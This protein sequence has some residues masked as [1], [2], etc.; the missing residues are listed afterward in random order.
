MKLSTFTRVILSLGL[1]LAFTASVTFALDPACY[2]DWQPVR[3]PTSTTAYAKVTIDGAPAEAGDVVGAFVNGECRDVADVTVNDGNAYATLVISGASTETVAFKLWDASACAAFDIDLT[4]TSAPGETIG[5]PPDFL[6]MN[7]D[8]SDPN[9]KS[10]NRIEIIPEISEIEPGK[11]FKTNVK[12]TGTNIWAAHVEIIPQSGRFEPYRKGY[13]TSDNPFFAGRKFTLPRMFSED[14]K[15]IGGISLKHPEEP[16][17]GEGGFAF[18]VKYRVVEGTYGEATLN[19]A[20]SLSDKYGNLLPAKVVP[21]TIFI[22][23]GIHGGDNVI[24]GTVTSPDGAPAAG[25][26]VTISIDG[27]EY[28]VQT[29]ENGHYVFEDINDLADGEVYQIEVT[30]GDFYGEATV[31][32]DSLTNGHAPVPDIV[33][34]NTKLADLNEDGVINVAD[35]TLLS[36]SYGL[37]EGDAGYDARADL[38]GDQSVTI[39]DLALLGSHWKI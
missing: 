18:A 16:I 26:D 32:S 39:Q 8:A 38:N 6:A 34:L 29:D 28:T 15:W 25:V 20:V 24:N 2:P 37:S 4:T 31:D 3:Y 10:N 30:N 5:Y 22:D 23:D 14:G 17:S 36:S 27:H 11:V 19:G 35:F 7:A 9:P 1:I 33:I 21:A 13:Y 12:L